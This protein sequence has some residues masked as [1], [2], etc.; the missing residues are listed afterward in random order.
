MVSVAGVNRSACFCLKGARAVHSKIIC[1]SSPI[2]PLLQAK[3]TQTRQPESNASNR[4]HYVDI[5]T[6]SLV[7]GI[8]QAYKEVSH[9]HRDVVIG[10]I[11]TSLHPP[12]SCALSASPRSAAFGSR[13]RCISDSNQAK[14]EVRR[15]GS[16]FA[17]NFPAAAG[18]GAAFA[19]LIRWTVV[20]HGFS[21]WTGSSYTFRKGGTGHVANPCRSAMYLKPQ[22]R[23]AVGLYRLP[24]ARGVVS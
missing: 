9:L 12:W 16:G 7:R 11:M 3:Q 6:T 23:H 24:T 2:A 19:V 1:F 5:I 4:H 21:H 8:F 13:C 15:A 20:G 10:C 17:T 18:A 14:H 22:K